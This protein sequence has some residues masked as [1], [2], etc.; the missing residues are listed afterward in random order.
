MLL[1]NCIMSIFSPFND[2][3]LSAL[4]S[5]LY[6]TTL[7]S[8]LNKR[9]NNYRFRPPFFL[10]PTNPERDILLRMLANMNAKE[11]S[12]ERSDRSRTPSTAGR[13][14]SANVPKPPPPKTSGV[15]H[16]TGPQ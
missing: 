13:P 14:L 16:W 8:T 2:N 10:F 11:R 12:G 1:G 6:V 3:N 9:L 7:F 4:I 5:A 15:S